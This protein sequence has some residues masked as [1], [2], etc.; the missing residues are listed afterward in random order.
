MIDPVL[1][2]VAGLSV[3]SPFSRVPLGQ[4]DISVSTYLCLS[5]SCL[6]SA[7]C[8]RM[9]ECTCACVSVMCVEV[10]LCIFCVC[11]SECGMCG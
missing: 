4:S 7:V 10:Y 11:V 3:Q 9:Y 8:I 6:C 1:V 5:Y 2:V